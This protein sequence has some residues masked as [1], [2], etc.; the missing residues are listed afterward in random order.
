MNKCCPNIEQGVSIFEWKI[1]RQHHTRISLHIYEMLDIK[2]TYSFNGFILLKRRKSDM[3]I[4][5][6]NLNLTRLRFGIE[7]IAES[8]ELKMLNYILWIKHFMCEMCADCVLY[9][10]MIQDLKFFGP[11]CVIWIFKLSW[12]KAFN[13]NSSMFL[14]LVKLDERHRIAGVYNF[15]VPSKWLLMH[16][17]YIIMKIKKKKK[18]KKT[19][20]SHFHSFGWFECVES[21]QSM[22][23][24]KYNCIISQTQFTFKIRIHPQNEKQ[25]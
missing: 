15:D 3:L 18:N 23:I 4:T 8:W 7:P 24:T 25:I 1:K 11:H 2:F 14:Q 5:F 13:F 19:N 9:R 22:R 16:V 10:W 17:T 6:A 21:I 12:W 20:N